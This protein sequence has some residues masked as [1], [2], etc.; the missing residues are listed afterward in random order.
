MGRFWH[1]IRV[2][3]WKNMLLMRRKPA[4]QFFIFAS[5]IILFGLFGGELK[6]LVKGSQKWSCQRPL[7]EDS[8]EC[9]WPPFTPIL[10]NTNTDYDTFP[11]GMLGENFD[12]RNFSDMAMG[13][14]H[15]DF[16]LYVVDGS[17][18]VQRQL[19][20]SAVTF[21]NTRFAAQAAAGVGL[22]WRVTPHYTDEAGLSRAYTEMA[23]TNLSVT[24]GSGCF[25]GV[26][27]ANGREG[28]DLELVFRPPYV[29]GGFRNIIAWD[30][31]TTSLSTRTW[32]TTEDT[33]PAS[34][35]F[36][37][38]PRMQDLVS[39]F[40]A[41]AD[42]LG[43]S[44]GY[45]FNAFLAIQ[46]AFAVAFADGDEEVE[47]Q[48]LNLQMN[49]LPYPQY[50]SDPWAIILL[51]AAP[52]AIFLPMMFAS[53]QLVRDM[54]Q[55]KEDKIKAAMK[56]MGVQAIHHWTA[57]FLRGMFSIGLALVVVTIVS[58][59]LDL[60]PV[61]GSILFVFFILSAVAVTAQTFLVSTL[62]NKATN[63]ALCAG[64]GMYVSL[65]PFQYGVSQQATSNQQIPIS[66]PNAQVAV[67]VLPGSCIGL[68]FYSIAGTVVLED[69][70]SWANIMHQPG[71]QSLSFGQVLGML[72]ADIVW[73]SLL[74]AYI[75]LVFPGDFGVPL[76]PLFP[77]IWIQNAMLGGG[78]EPI[79]S[80]VDL[81]GGQAENVLPVDATEVIGLHTENLTK[82]FPART[83][84]GAAVVAVNNLSLPMVKGQI[85]ALLGENGAG[86]TTT[87]SMLCGLYPPTDGAMRVEGRDVLENQNYMHKELGVC[88]QH[89][90][91]WKTLTVIEHL[92]LFGRLKGVPPENLQAAC[93]AMVGDLGLVDKTMAQTKT[94]SGGQKRRLSCGIALIGG[95]S[96]VLLDEPTSG[97][98]PKARRDIWDLLLRHKEGRTILLSTHFMD[99]A[100]GT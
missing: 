100:D 58:V 36:I 21:L 95:S 73:M 80:P 17:G 23:A 13:C 41:T 29:P 69:H 44:P 7:T 38:S 5:P 16:S 61:D 90:V 53:S 94:L 68:G 1:I 54:V 46:H 22:A 27:F 62:F 43:D 89:D 65:L 6:P 9:S 81:E 55:E 63:A 88:P 79:T 51:S 45:A 64:L 60:F 99:E 83:S 59:A 26:Q 92:Y 49:R 86:K 10:N 84:G 25:F 87:M 57:W 35:I 56:M 66:D 72:F 37:S 12:S 75:E 97:C 67:C 24:G 18:T 78:R 52:W 76:H 8:D 34:P 82:V 32:H 77:F 42:Q 14:G 71:P 39:F 20:T 70:I 40:S 19:V 33:P 91:L 98:D 15:E 2:L 31:Q 48:L 3:S 96:V 28:D 74:A 4:V 50:N 93:A 30:Q 85:T 11:F 47:S